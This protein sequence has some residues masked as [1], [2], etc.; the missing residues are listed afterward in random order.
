MRTI[1]G[2]NPFAVAAHFKGGGGFHKDRRAGRGGARNNQSDLLA[3]VQE[4]NDQEAYLL[5]CD[6]NDENLENSNA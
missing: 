1:V 6:D 2:R 3:E 4:E 5:G